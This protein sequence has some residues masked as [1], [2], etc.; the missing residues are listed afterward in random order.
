MNT[1]LQDLLTKRIIEKTSQDKATAKKMLA[2]AENDITVAED[3]LTRGH[4]SWALAIAYN[5]MLSAGRALMAARGYRTAAESHHLAVV[6]FCAAAM[7]AESEPLAGIFNRYRIRRHDVVY[8]QASP[9]SDGE[10]RSAIAKAREFVSK[11]KS[12]CKI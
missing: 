4:F 11:I 10:A 9:A 8:G 6:Q 7:P 12:M 5:A 2:S 3:N 1:N